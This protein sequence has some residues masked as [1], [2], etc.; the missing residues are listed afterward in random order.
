MRHE[1][2]GYLLGVLDPA[3]QRLVEQQLAR[4]EN[5]RREMERIRA[6]LESLRDEEVGDPPPDLVARTCESVEAFSA[7]H[8]PTP[9]Q[10]MKWVS[11]RIKCLI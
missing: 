7:E 9:A 11:Y 6:K 5:L 8:K 2:I 3:E 4:D 1:L 10:R